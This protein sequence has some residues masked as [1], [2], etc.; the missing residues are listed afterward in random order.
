MFFF[1]DFL[2]NIFLCNSDKNDVVTTL[3]KRF[4]FRANK[5]LQGAELKSETTNEH[6][7]KQTILSFMKKKNSF[8]QQ[9]DGGQDQK[10]EEVAATAPATVEKNSVANTDSSSPKNGRTHFVA[11]CSSVGEV[12]TE[13][14]SD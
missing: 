11:K 9:N 14:D 3:E 13:S 10:V 8:P 5:I 12:D 1:G 4:E 6:S 7:F 2:I